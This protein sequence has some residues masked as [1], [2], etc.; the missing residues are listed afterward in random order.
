MSD[1]KNACHW[2]AATQIEIKCK[3][4]K[5]W[6]N[7]PPVPS[8]KD[9]HNRSYNMQTNR[10][11]FYAIFK[12]MLVDFFPGLPSGLR[13]SESCLP[14]CLPFGQKL[15]PALYDFCANF[16]QLG[17]LFVV[18]RQFLCLWFMD[19]GRPDASCLSMPAY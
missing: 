6:P 5:N 4:G 2:L 10:C 8:T 15:F 17:I 16:R 18:C 14:A 11:Y 3:V 9:N 1:H 13:H 19:D 7:A 12:L